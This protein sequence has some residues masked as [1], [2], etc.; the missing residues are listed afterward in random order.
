[1][2]IEKSELAKRIDKLKSVVPKNSPMAALQGIL[3]KEDKLI[4]SNGEMTVK[5]KIGGMEGES[6]IIP[7]KAF[8]LIKN[9]PDGEV[10]ITENQ[11]HIVT[12][13]IGKIK[14][15]Y[16]SFP[17]E[18]YP[19]SADRITEGG[20]NTTIPANKLKEAMRHV[21]YAIPQKSPNQPMGALC[22]QAKGGKLNYVGLDGHVLAWDQMDL[23]GD[24]ELLIPR[25]AVEKLLS[26]EMGEQ[27]SIEFDK[28]C[29]IFR[30][31]E[32][33]INTR[34]V[35][36]AYFKFNKMFSSLPMETSVIRR[37]LLNAIVRAKLCTD[38]RTPTKFEIEG[39]TLKLSIKDSTADYSEIVQLQS[40]MENLLIGFNSSLVMETLK[41]FDSEELFLSFGG[42]KQPMI[43]RA[44]SMQ[45]IVLPVQLGGPNEKAGP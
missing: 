15:S 32:Y 41:A 19:F 27:I 4:A 3:A 13:K 43:V 38:E 26:L 45:A 37:E 22:L 39:D 31:D 14:N 12:I 36:G 40:K 7:A 20:G 25:S 10:S 35:E 23:D 28:N 1:M 16:Q 2:K 6:F 33:E 21:L 17:A 11:K 34:L 42:S 29:A 24:F 30:S 9:L 8:D 5:A 18:E 44:G